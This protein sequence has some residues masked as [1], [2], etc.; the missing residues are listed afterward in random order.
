MI[1]SKFDII[2]LQKLMILRDKLV[3]KILYGLREAEKTGDMNLVEELELLVSEASMVNQEI[4]E[5]LKKKE[6]K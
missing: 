3:N 2:Q 1:E 4:N 5:I 6:D